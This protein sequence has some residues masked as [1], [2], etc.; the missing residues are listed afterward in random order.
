MNTEWLYAQ[1]LKGDEIAGAR[2]QYNGKEPVFQ[3]ERGDSEGSC[4]N[5]RTQDDPS[6]H[7]KVLPE[8]DGFM[9]THPS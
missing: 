7:V 2:C 6:E 9:I 5:Q 8:S 3:T 4:N 1:P